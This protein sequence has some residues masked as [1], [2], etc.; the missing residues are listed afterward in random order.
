MS[1][2][3]L[4]SMVYTY[5]MW[6]Y[7]VPK[8]GENISDLVNTA[9]KAGL[10]GLWCKYS[11]GTNTLWSS[12]YVALAEALKHVGIL[13]VPW[14]VVYPR[15]QQKAGWGQMV[16]QASEY[17]ATYAPIEPVL[18]EPVMDTWASDAKLYGSV[19]S[20]AFFSAFHTQTN[21]EHIAFCCWGDPSIQPDF[22]WQ[23]WASYCC[24]VLPEIY[25]EAYKM[26]PAKI[27]NIAF[28]G[29]LGR[30]PGLEKIGVP[31]VPTFDLSAIS[32]CTKLAENGGFG[33]IGWWYLDAITEQDAATIA[34][35][36]RDMPHETGE[37][38]GAG[39]G[40]Q[41]KVDTSRIVAL[42]QEALKLLE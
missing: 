32:E 37:G 21:G 30:G 35:L 42:L 34:G 40:E 3:S 10:V 31:V 38:A 22:P 12:G 27:Y 14:M 26:T 8:Q 13:C 39:A 23:P 16:R 1:L 9:L 5:G 33:T 25:P 28:L 6:A 18:L 17:A 7:H 4:N 20:I 24:G 19:S 15:D 36:A 2:K 29:G 41:G 11:D